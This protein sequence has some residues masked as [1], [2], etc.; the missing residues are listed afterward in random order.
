MKSNSSGGMTKLSNEALTC[1][2][3]SAPPLNTIA[4][5]QEQNKKLRALIDVNSFITTSLDKRTVLKAILD[6]TRILLECENISVL[7]IDEE[8]KK[9]KF[10]VVTN[11]ADMEKLDPI[12]L[13]MGEGIAGTV[14]KN[15]QPILIEDTCFDS[16]FS[17]LADRQT[18]YQ[19]KTVMAVPLVVNGQI[20]GVLEAINKLNER[21]FNN[22]D[23]EL[24]QKISIQSAIAIENAHLYDLAITDGMTKLFINKYFQRR[25]LESFRL[26]ERYQ[27]ELSLLMIDL[28]HFKRINDIYG[29]QMGDEVLI[30][31]AEIIRCNVRS[32]DLPCR[33][34]GEEFSV[35][36]N[37]T[38][39]DQAM[40][41]AERIRQRVEN[42]EVEFE[43]SIIKITI[44]GGIV[45]FKS[46]QPKSSQ[47]MI[48]KADL[49]LYHS[50]HQGRN[51]ITEWNSTLKM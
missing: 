43:D 24:F 2:E 41:V 20:L 5:L 13:G 39:L 38:A 49:S 8:A 44:S 26:S 6:Q 45:S 14:W 42:M 3:Y 33:Y 1:S 15:G 16:R 51:Q 11:E 27:T 35:I 48:K 10:A 4:E 29:H 22:F 40:I 31:T 47:D 28:D 17:M 21:N 18:K 30:R 46:H 9:L 12:R 34:G 25:L 36:L 23:L 7:L 37:N 32:T 50:K 19:T